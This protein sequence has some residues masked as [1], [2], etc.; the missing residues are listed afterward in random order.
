MSDRDIEWFKG[1]DI[2]N[3]DIVYEKDSNGKNIE[4]YRYYTFTEGF[5]Y[6]FKNDLTI[7]TDEGANE[8][9]EVA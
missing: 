3:W 2:S 8:H 9:L 7:L 5:N 1:L 4:K 6:S